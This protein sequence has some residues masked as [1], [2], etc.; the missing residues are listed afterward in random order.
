[1]QW[2]LQWGGQEDFL[3][4]VAE[5]TGVTPPGLQSKPQLNPEAVTVW[6]LFSLLDSS[7]TYGFSGPDP[8][9]V[10]EI[11]AMLDMVGEDDVEHRLFILRLMKRLDL[12]YF[13]HLESKRDTS[14]T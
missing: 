6:N 10:S 14:I 7:R 3:L 11:K 1:M 12:I 4:E 2:Q 5:T 8:L 9:L 13:K